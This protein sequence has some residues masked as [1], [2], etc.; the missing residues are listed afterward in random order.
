[1]AQL[2][3]SITGL[4][5]ESAAQ[6]WLLDRCQALSSTPAEAQKLFAGVVLAAWTAGDDVQ[7]KLLE[8][9]GCGDDALALARE[10]LE[11]RAE[12]AA[13]G[14]LPHVADA[15][16][17]GASAPKRARTERVDRARSDG[18]GVMTTIR[19]LA[20]GALDTSLLAQPSGAIKLY[21]QR[22]SC[23]LYTSPSPRD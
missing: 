21:T 2:D 16:E 7:E 1:M 13:L 14:L 22:D 10:V 17:G 4:G 11:R 23:L 18:S 5:G 15:R 20:C 19:S 8:A 6:A 12:I 9:L 3:A